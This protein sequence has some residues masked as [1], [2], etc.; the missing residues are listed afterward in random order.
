MALS[1]TDKEIL[2]N[3]VDREIELVTEQLAAESF[4]IPLTRTAL[5]SY[6]QSLE[7]IAERL[8]Q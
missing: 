1:R 4:A 2:S 7:R 6:K 5:V 3:L 8:T